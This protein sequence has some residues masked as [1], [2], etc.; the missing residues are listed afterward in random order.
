M[1]A[2]RHLYLTFF[3]HVGRNWTECW[4]K[5]LTVSKGHPTFISKIF[6]SIVHSF[7]YFQSGSLQGC[8]CDGLNRACRFRLWKPL[9]RENKRMDEKEERKW[10][11]PKY[12]SRV[13]GWR[14][15]GLERYVPHECHWLWVLIKP[16]F[17]P[18][19]PEWENKWKPCLF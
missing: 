3:C 18:H 10:L 9:P 14:P 15:N 6:F 7:F 17:W 2:G 16:K 1:N 5:I 12:I 13:K 19:F 4:M 8:S 11:L